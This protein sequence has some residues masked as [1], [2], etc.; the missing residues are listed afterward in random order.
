MP[1]DLSGLKDEF[2]RILNKDEAPEPELPKAELP[3]AS[4][5][6]PI[7]TQL[8]IKWLPLSILFFGLAFV[9]WNIINVVFVGRYHDD[10]S[11]LELRVKMLENELR[12]LKAK[13]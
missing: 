6:I 8:W 3:R 5:N 9:S 13:K 7:L 4:V 12:E 10:L 1:D 11:R 2:E